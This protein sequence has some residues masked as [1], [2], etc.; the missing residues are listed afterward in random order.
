VACSNKVFI[1]CLQDFC[2]R[3]QIQ[4]FEP[5]SAKKYI[6]VA[7]TANLDLERNMCM[8]GLMSVFIWR[9]RI[10]IDIILERIDKCLRQ[11][12]KKFLIKKQHVFFS[13]SIWPFW[14]WYSWSS[15]TTFIQEIATWIISLAPLT[16]PKKN[17][18][19][20]FLFLLQH[21][22]SSSTVNSC[23][24]WHLIV[25]IFIWCSGKKHYKYI[26]SF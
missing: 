13:L 22:D 20:N 9:I 11:E 16:A 3:K 2:G 1:I 14:P 25:L 10:V 18:S 15:C 21:H 23:Y 12:K 6:F 7:L 19:S 8:L 4:I 5:W 26:W 24:N 17:L